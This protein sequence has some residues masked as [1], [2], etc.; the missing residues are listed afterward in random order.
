VVQ[1]SRFLRPGE[2]WHT[3]YWPLSPGKTIHVTGA[4]TSRFYLGV[5]EK[6]FV[7][8]RFNPPAGARRPFPFVFTSDR[9]R[10]DLDFSPR[11]PGEYCV[12]IRLGVFNPAG[13]FLVTA[14]WL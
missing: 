13:R 14:D 5:Y 2:E 7:E 6:Q 10:H 11:R 3:P 12:V 8:P 9:F 4:G 1:F